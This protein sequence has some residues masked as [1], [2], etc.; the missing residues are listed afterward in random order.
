VATVPA[1]H[2]TP[3]ESDWRSQLLAAGIAAATHLGTAIPGLKQTRASITQPATVTTLARPGGDTVIRAVITSATSV[4][5]NACEITPPAV[6]AL[7]DA[8]H[9]ADLSDYPWTGVPELTY[10]KAFELNQTGNTVW[11]A[12]HGYTV[13]LELSVPQ[14]HQLLTALAPHLPTPDRDQTA[15]APHRA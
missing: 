4:L 1:H 12:E 7:I 5:V 10:H 2:F 15:A 14:T 13:R 6:E 3:T 8:A 11:K 9:A